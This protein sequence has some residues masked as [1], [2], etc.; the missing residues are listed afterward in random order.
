MASNY[1]RLGATTVSA[2]VDTGLYTVPAATQTV[3]SSIIVCNR[4][5]TTETFR[6]AHVDGAIGSVANEDYIYYD[7]E[8]AAN[9]TFIATVGLTMEATHTLLVRSSSAD[10]QKAFTGQVVQGVLR[11]Q[12]LGEAQGTEATED[13]GAGSEK[14]CRVLILWRPLH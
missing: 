5:T 10:S 6:V 9:D 7:I 11:T 4:G 13:Q 12:S 8:I 3:V 14:S 1:L 2:N